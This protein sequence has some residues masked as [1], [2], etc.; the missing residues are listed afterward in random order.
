MASIEDVSDG[1]L[2]AWADCG[3]ISSARYVEEVERRRSAYPRMVIQDAPPLD[4]AIDDEL[5]IPD[6]DFD[7][8]EST[9]VSIDA[10][11]TAVKW[12]ALIA[13]ALIVVAVWMVL[14]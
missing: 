14:P 11:P 1:M 2:R 7:L 10:A 8:S 12:V 5:V 9:D 6:I 3:V 4:C 13:A